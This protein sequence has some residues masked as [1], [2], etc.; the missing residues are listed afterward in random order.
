[1]A[2]RRRLLADTGRTPE[3]IALNK[4]V[5][6]AIR[7]DTR[8]DIARRVREMGPT[9]IFRNVRQI[10]AG[11]KSTD[12]SK[13]EATP[14]ELNQYFVSVGPQVASEVRARGHPPSF[15]VRLP[16]VGSCGFKLQPISTAHG[17]ILELRIRIRRIRID[18][19]PANIL[20][21]NAGIRFLKFRIRIPK[22]PTDPGIFA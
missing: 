7:H 1:M 17:P 10:I 5:R 2:Q 4:R 9:T 8:Q 3:F 20:V 6:S 13:P 21:Q 19:N 22:S 15:R 16:R 12:R 18:S 14:D 11:K